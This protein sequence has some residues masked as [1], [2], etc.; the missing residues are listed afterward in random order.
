MAS[1][2]SAPSTLPYIVHELNVP[3]NALKTATCLW[4]KVPHMSTV[5]R[6][7]VHYIFQY[8]PY[9]QINLML[10]PRPPQMNTGV[11]GPGGTLMALFGMGSERRTP[12]IP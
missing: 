10:S 3:L 2:E 6:K 9:S 11:R 4:V 8:A 12:A 1:R 5:Q 7:T